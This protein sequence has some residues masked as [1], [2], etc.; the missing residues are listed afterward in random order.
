MIKFFLIAMLLIAAYPLWAGEEKEA[1]YLRQGAEHL[2]VGNYKRAAKAFGHAARLNSDSAEAHAGMG[3]AYLKLGSGEVSTD[4]ELLGN[5][6]AAFG[7]ALR[8]APDSAESRYHL[9]LTCLALYDRKG[10]LKAYEALKPLDEELAEQLLAGIS[11]FKPPPSFRMEKSGGADGNVTRVTIAGNGVLVPVTLAHG[12]RV[13]QATLL[14]DTGASITVIS[15][16]IAEKLDIDLDRAGQARVQVVGGGIV[17]AWHTRLDRLIAG[18]HTKTGQ[19]VAIV[20]H[21][22]GGFTVDGLLGM[23][24]LRS[25]KYH[26]DFNNQAINW[27]P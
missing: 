10:A 5:A 27:I 26:I 1:E 13:V 7:E 22:G 4:P 6:A 8:L 16:E 20:P 25:F 15:R 24:F 2:G 14:L 11:S 18:P 17:K 21:K 19:N 3:M 12:D 23:D 9:G